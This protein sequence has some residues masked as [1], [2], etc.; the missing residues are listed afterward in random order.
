M[1]KNSIV[2]GTIYDYQL[3]RISHNFSDFFFKVLEKGIDTGHE[4][5]VHLYGGIAIPKAIKCGLTN[6]DRN[7]L[8][9]KVIREYKKGYHF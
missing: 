9:A 4:L 2:S 1:K 3:I 6:A 5:K 8:Y 7:K